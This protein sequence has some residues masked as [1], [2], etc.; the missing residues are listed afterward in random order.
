MTRRRRVA[1]RKIVAAEARRGYRSYRELPDPPRLLPYRETAFGTILD[2]SI[3]L[4]RAVPVISRRENELRPPVEGRSPECIHRT[5]SPA[6]SRIGSLKRR[7]RAL[8][9]G[10]RQE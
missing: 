4:A 6:G 8:N 9:C 5:T 7:H 3:D 10:R 2:G 1:L